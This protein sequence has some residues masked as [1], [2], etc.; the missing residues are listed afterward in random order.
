MSRILKIF[1]FFPQKG[2]RKFSHF[3]CDSIF[4]TN[5]T[6]KYFN[7][8]SLMRT[9]FTTM[10]YIGLERD[11]CTCLS[12]HSNVSDCFRLQC[13]TR[14]HSFCIS[15]DLGQRVRSWW[16]N[17]KATREGEHVNVVTSDS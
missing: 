15:M 14:K 16:Q 4:T 10:Q 8:A 5:N 12:S 9:S 11:R 13:A 17:V 3:F 7:M 2:I 1:F 6:R